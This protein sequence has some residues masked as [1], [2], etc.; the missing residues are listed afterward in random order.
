MH[1]KNEINFVS[2]IANLLLWVLWERLMMLINN[3]SITLQETLMPQNVE[4]NL[5]ETMMFSCMQKINFISNFFFWNI[6]NTLNL[7]F[8]KLWKCL[9]I[10]SKI[11]VSICRKLWCWS[12]F[13]KSTSSLTSFLRYCKEIANLLFWVIWACLVTDT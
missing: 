7:L 10:P 12:I 11:M 3:D 13:K 1:A 2:D 4:I 9:I 8:L 5:S 6:V